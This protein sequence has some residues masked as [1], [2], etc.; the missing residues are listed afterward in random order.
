MNWLNPLTATELINLFVAVSLCSSRVFCLLPYLAK[1]LGVNIF[2]D[3]FECSGW[4][5]IGSHRMMCRSLRVNFSLA[6]QSRKTVSC[7]QVGKESEFT[8]FN[9][10]VSLIIHFLKRTSSCSFS[11]F[12]SRYLLAT[13]PDNLY[14]SSRIVCEFGRCWISFLLK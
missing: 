1:K 9:G 12:L 10:Y 11:K 13:F 8:F 2:Y 7:S 3:P 5:N 6:W 4:S 14:L